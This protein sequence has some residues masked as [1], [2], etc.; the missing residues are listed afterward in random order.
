MDPMTGIKNRS[1]YNEYMQE[2]E[3]MIKSPNKKLV[4]IYMD[5]ND[6]KCVNDTLGHEKGDE[7][8]VDTASLIRGAFGDFS[9]F[10]IGGDEFVAILQDEEAEREEKLI[11]RFKGDIQMHNSQNHSYGRL[12]IAIGVS[13]YHDGDSLDDLFTRADEKMYSDKRKYKNARYSDY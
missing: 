6:L 12:S 11:K 8:L 3:E 5:V 10:R 9:T 7:M 2:C 1:A 13:I 4:F